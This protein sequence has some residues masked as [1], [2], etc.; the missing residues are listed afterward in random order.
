MINNIN[1]FGAHTYG[2]PCF[3]CATKHVLK[4]VEEEV[5]SVDREPPYFLYAV[6]CV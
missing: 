4:I 1:K 3:L 5:W 2:A 6:L